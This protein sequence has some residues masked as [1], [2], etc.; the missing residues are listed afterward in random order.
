MK[1]NIE[2]KISCV[3][4]ELGQNFKFFRKYY[5][6]HYCGIPDSV[7]HE[8]FCRDLSMMT[9]K[10]V[11]NLPLPHPGIAARARLSARFM[12]FIVSVTSLKISL[13]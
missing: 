8:E 7:F 2:N 1:N 11:L 9:S 13:C 4:R 10:R 3:T 6:S 12:L 5:F